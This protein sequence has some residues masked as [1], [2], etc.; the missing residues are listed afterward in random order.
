MKGRDLI[1]CIQKYGLEDHD[2]PICGEDG[3]IVGYIS[4]EDVAHT[5]KI[6]ISKIRTIVRSHN[7]KIVNIL[8][9][10]LIPQDEIE[11]VLNDPEYIKE[12]SEKKKERVRNG[13]LRQKRN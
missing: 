2:F 10:E 6:P 1:E 4:I 13:I 7:I 11:A 8:N 12:N 5:N 9:K 3:G